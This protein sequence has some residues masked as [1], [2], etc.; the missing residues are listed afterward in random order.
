M[1]TILGAFSEAWAFFHTPSVDRRAMNR[2]V[3]EIWQ[4]Q[5]RLQRARG[6]SRIV[7]Q[8]PRTGRKPAYRELQSSARGSALRYVVRLRMSGML[9]KFFGLRTP[10]QSELQA[11][12]RRKFGPCPLCQRELLAHKLALL[13]SAILANGD[14]SAASILEDLVNG[15]KWQEAATIR[16]WRGDADELEYHVIKCPSDQ[17]V[18]VLKV[19]SFG[20]LWADDLVENRIVLNREETLRIVAAGSLEWWSL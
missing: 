14:T 3:C 17:R 19:R 20:E 13:G 7:K 16:E 15:H 11:V 6:S 4:A 9:S 2:Q 12:A 10:K 5:E 8:P 1:L 18:A